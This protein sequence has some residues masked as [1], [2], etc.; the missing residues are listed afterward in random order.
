VDVNQTVAV[1]VLT[2]KWR[3]CYGWW[4]GEV[5]SLRIRKDSPACRFTRWK[6][7]LKSP[8]STWQAE[9]PQRLPSSSE[10]SSG[11]NDVWLFALLCRFSETSW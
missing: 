4:T 3:C 6:T 2:D 11:L 9:S 7:W 1:C 10:I 8:A 5:E